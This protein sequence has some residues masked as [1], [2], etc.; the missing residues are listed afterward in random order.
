[1]LDSAGGRFLD[2]AHDAVAAC[3]NP[4]RRIRHVPRR[5]RVDIAQAVVLFVGWMAAFLLGKE[6]QSG[7]AQWRA[8]RQQ[9]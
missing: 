8:S 4:H 1:V 9:R 2:S 3:R 6:L 7:F 5:L